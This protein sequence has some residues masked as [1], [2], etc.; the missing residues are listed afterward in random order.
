MPLWP[1]PS[2]N[3]RH[4]HDAEAWEV[5]LQHQTRWGL[6]LL[7]WNVPWFIGPRARKIYPDPLLLRLQENI[8]KTSMKNNWRALDSLRRSV[9]FLWETCHSSKNWPLASSKG[10]L[11]NC[12]PSKTYLFGIVSIAIMKFLPLSSSGTFQLDPKLVTLRKGP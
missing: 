2:A 10:L 1:K 6:W 9:L 8:W 7:T 3:T 5:V 12:I 4:K 11:N